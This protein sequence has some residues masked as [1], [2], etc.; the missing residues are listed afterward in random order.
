[1]KHKDKTPPG[2]ANSMVSVSRRNP[3]AL[4][5]CREKVYSLRGRAEV[6]SDCVLKGQLTEYQ[7]LKLF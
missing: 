6:A 7:G 2:K 1:M 5:A 4:N 3:P